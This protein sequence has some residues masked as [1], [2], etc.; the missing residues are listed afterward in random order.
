[1]RQLWRDVQTQGFTGSLSTVATFVAK[2]RYPASS[3]PLSLPASVPPAPSSLTPRQAAW[4]ILA[5][6]ESLTLEQR[7]QAGQL[8]SIHAEVAH[9]VVEA[10]SFATMLRVR[11]VDA[12]DAWLERATHSPCREL[13]SFARGIRRDYAAV[14][15]ALTL[16]WNNGLVEGQVN[17]LKFF[18][19]QMFGRANF[20]LLRLRILSTADH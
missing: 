20:D 11:Q 18:K 9:M 13:T 7:E 1:M 6:E 19:R 4:L 16:H 8:A 2:T 12:L 3:L 17:R 14:K 10:R 15:N 5:R